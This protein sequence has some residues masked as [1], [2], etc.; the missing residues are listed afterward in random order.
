LIQGLSG[1]PGGAVISSAAMIL[2]L[3]Q[4]SCGIDIQKSAKINL[5][6]IMDSIE[7]SVELVW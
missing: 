2:P 4:K 1:R 7:F 3:V 6:I 5:Y